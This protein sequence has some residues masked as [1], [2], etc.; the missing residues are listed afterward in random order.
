MLGREV[1]YVDAA[2]LPVGAIA[3]D[4]FNGANDIVIGRLP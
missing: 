2:Q 1:H 4:R 3:D